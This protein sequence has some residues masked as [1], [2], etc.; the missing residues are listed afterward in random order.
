MNEAVRAF[1]RQ[2]FELVPFR[3]DA[4]SSSE[5]AFRARTGEDFVLSVL[6]DRDADSAWRGIVSV[7]PDT[8]S[9]DARRANVVVTSDGGLDANAKARIR[10]A[11]S[12]L[13]ARGHDIETVP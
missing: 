10:A 3:A 8:D 5:G 13:P 11:L 1:G 2:G 4:N 9:F 7:G 12:A 6:S